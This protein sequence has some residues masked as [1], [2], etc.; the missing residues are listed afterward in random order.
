MSMCL[1]SHTVLSLCVYKVLKLYKYVFTISHTYIDMYLQS[2]SV[3]L[4]CIYK[5]KQFHKYV[6]TKLHRNIYSCIQ[7][8][9]Q[10]INELT[11]FLCTLLNC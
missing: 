6:L 7:F 1:K 9:K 3:I 2:H 5:L 4:T 10:Y 8:T 11:Q